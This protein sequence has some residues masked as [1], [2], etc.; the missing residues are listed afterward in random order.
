MPAGS[1]VAHVES[2]LKAEA[3]KKGY[4][5]RRAD[6]YVYGT[7]NKTGLKHGNKTTDKGMRHYVAVRRMAGGMA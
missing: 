6:A 1:V 3:R 2:K 7:L 4:K 5:G